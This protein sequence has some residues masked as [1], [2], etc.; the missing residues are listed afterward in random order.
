MSL[1]FNTLSRFFMAFLPRSKHLLISVAAVTVLS[2]FVAHK[3]K[4]L[5]FKIKPHDFWGSSKEVGLIRYSSFSW[6]VE[7]LCDTALIEPHGPKFIRGTFYLQLM[8]VII[9]SWLCVAQPHKHF[10]NLMLS[11][12]SLTLLALK[13][14]ALSFKLLSHNFLPSLQAMYST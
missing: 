11:Y 4:N 2:D 1:L 10:L 9:I 3:S 5:T 12:G 8:F 6:W 7:F 13:P 14:T